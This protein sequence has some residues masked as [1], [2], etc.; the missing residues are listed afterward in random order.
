MVKTISQMLAEQRRNA[1]ARSRIQM[2]IIQL[3]N[4][5]E[6]MVTIEGNTFPKAIVL[7]ELRKMLKG[8]PKIRPIHMNIANH[9]TRNIVDYTGAKNEA[10]VTMLEIAKAIKSNQPRTKVVKQKN[11]QDPFGTKINFSQSSIKELM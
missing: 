2:L 10:S 1:Q 5:K 8:L 3:E 4:I 11:K 7:A 6:E 9:K